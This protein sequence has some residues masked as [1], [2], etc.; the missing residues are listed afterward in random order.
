MKSKKVRY[1]A[2]LKSMPDLD[3]TTYRCDLHPRWSTDGNFVIVDT[4]NEF[5]RQIYVYKV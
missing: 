4:T 1:I 2:K 3:K 5:F